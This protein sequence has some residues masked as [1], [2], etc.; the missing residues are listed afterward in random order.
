MLIYPFNR[1]KLSTS[2]KVDRICTY[3]GVTPAQSLWRTLKISR[4]ITRTH[5]RTHTSSPSSSHRAVLASSSIVHLQARDF[6]HLAH[7]RPSPSFPSCI[8]T[9]YLLAHRSPPFS[10]VS[11]FH[12][13]QT[14]YL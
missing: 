14:S 13:N 1:I 9:Y 7:A 2:C 10:L 4:Q 11:P 3:H 12:P 8:Y 5:G 6:L